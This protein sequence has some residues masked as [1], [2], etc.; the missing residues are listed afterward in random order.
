MG[1]PTR[2]LISYA[3]TCL[4]LAAAGSARAQSYY[5]V[6][7]DG[8]TIYTDTFDD[9]PAPQPPCTTYTTIDVLLGTYGGSSTA[10]YPGTAHVAFSTQAS[11]GVA[12][13]WSREIIHHGLQRGGNCGVFSDTTVVWPVDALRKIRAYYKNKGS[14]LGLTTYNRCNPNNACDSLL[15]KQSDAFVLLT[16]YQIQIGVGLTCSALPGDRV[17]QTMCMSP[18]PIP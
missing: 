14:F 18:D 5:D 11:I 7:F 9:A 13:Q 10:Y 15:S 8:A 1:R 17:P 12:Y 3:G 16:V 6:T 2:Y 4:V